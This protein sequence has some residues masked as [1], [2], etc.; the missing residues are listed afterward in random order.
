MQVARCTHPTRQIV[1]PSEFWLEP[2]K[3]RALHRVRV[4]HHQR[5]SA[6][7]HVPE[8]R[9]GGRV[10]PSSGDKNASCVL[11]SEWKSACV[12]LQLE[13]GH[14]AAV[15]DAAQLRM[16]ARRTK[17][18][19]KRVVFVSMVRRAVCVC[20]CVCVCACVRVCVRACAPR[21]SMWMRRNQI[22]PPCPT[23]STGAGC[24]CIGSTWGQRHRRIGPGDRSLPNRTTLQMIRPTATPW[25]P[26]RL[27]RLVIQTPRQP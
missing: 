25:L 9:V 13:H 3:Q 5:C 17:R 15:V 7:R 2:L 22:G 19:R 26:P 10:G 8:K 21:V 1:L 12:A 4:Q 20:V 24:R 18:Q 27:L 6:V 23:W 16:R 14:N 11:G